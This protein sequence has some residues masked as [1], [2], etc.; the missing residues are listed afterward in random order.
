[1]KKKKGRRKGRA[2]LIMRKAT[3]F[4]AQCQEGHRLSE[5]YWAS[6]YL[7]MLARSTKPIKTTG[8]V[9]DWLLPL[10]VNAWKNGKAK[11]FKDIARTIA[12]GTE[13]VHADQ[14]AHNLLTHFLED[15]FEEENRKKCYSIAEIQKICGGK[16]SERTAGR[17]AHDFGLKI[18]PRG[19]PSKSANKV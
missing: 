17:Y 3:K 2:P 5:A 11:F 14:A 6:I 19:A 7:K 12:R 13:N 8:T 10:F 1:M 9:A 4:L 16:I 18:R 15:A